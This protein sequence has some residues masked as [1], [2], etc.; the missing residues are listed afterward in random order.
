[1]KYLFI[2]HTR[3]IDQIKNEPILFI[4]SGKSDR[5]M[6]QYSILVKQYSISSREYDFWNNMKQVNE[7]GGD[8]FAKQPFSV[9]SNIHN[10]NNPKERVLGL[11]P[12]LSCEAEKKI[13]SA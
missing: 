11:F 13:R 9:T 7:S 3:E 12:G 2:L 5:L 10:I 1:M 6:L 8:I 4:D